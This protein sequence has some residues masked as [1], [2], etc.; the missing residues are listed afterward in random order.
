MVQKF[1]R[2]PGVQ[3]HFE[4][5]TGP[6]VLDRAALFVHYATGARQRQTDFGLPAGHSLDA[7]PGD[8]AIIGRLR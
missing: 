5:V 7:A 2:T 4:V 1:R 8:I 6:A 3:Y